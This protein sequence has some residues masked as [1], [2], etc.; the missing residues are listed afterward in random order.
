MGEQVIIDISTAE[1]GMR[2]DSSQGF[3]PVP[4]LTIISHPMTHRVGERLLLEALMLGREILLSRNAPDF[5]QPGGALGTHLA[6]PFLSRKP[7][8]FTPGSE[9]QIRLDPGENQ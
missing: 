9:G 2:E 4:A 3:R 6:D 7:L 8:L 5:V 1:A